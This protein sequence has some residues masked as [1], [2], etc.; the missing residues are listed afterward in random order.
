MYEINNIIYVAKFI[1]DPD[2]IKIGFTKRTCEERIAGLKYMH[3]K[4]PCVSDV[5]LIAEFDFPLT[6]Q[7]SKVER[8]VH[9]I[10]SEHSVKFN[11]HREFFSINCIE[12]AVRILK[13]KQ[14]AEIELD[15]TRKNPTVGFYI[16]IDKVA[17][18]AHV[19]SLEMTEGDRYDTILDQI[20]NK[21]SD[22]IKQLLKSDPIRRELKK[23]E[24]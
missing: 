24:E 17:F 23:V 9:K 10:L 13:V 18:K 8:S 7:V 4:E 12:E 11:S 14:A 21:A 15:K 3:R 1:G 19:D 16:R 2:M 22:Y 20:E 6:T 5:K